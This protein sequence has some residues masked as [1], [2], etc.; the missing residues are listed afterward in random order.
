MQKNYYSQFQTTKNVKS[1][2]WLPEGQEVFCYTVTNSKGT[3]F[4]V[5]NYGATLTS[6]VIPISDSQK[7]DV[8]LGFEDLESYMHSFQLPSAPYLGAVVGRYAGRIKEGKFTLNGKTIHLPQNHGVH[9]LHGGPN[10]MSTLCWKLKQFDPEKSITLSCECTSETDGYP[11]T[12]HVAVTYLLTENNEIR[13]R[14]EAQTDE[15]TLLNL[16]Q[17]S[18]FNLDGHEQALGNQW[19]QIHASRILETDIHQIPT[20]NFLTNCPELPRINQLQKCPTAIDT[21]FVLDSG[22]T[23]AATLYSDSN[24]LQLTVSTNQPAVHVYVG[25]NCFGKIPGKNYARYHSQ[26]GICFE[27]QNFPDAPNHA[28]FPSA[29]LKKGECYVNETQFAFKLLS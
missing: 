11:G 7:V 25:G 22:F 14:F 16:T 5:L 2:G 6:L 1:L 10:G 13:V 28:H 21:T 26:S 9:H 3:S 4:S 12:L 19:V 15:D 20:G 27:T 17:H 29:V 23:T 8:V 18:Y 24:R